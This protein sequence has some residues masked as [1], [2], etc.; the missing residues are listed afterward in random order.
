MARTPLFVLVRY[1][2]VRQN[3]LAGS[4]HPNFVPPRD[5]S[6]ILR[7]VTFEWLTVCGP[8]PG[9]DQSA[10]DTAAASTHRVQVFVVPLLVAG[11]EC[12][13]LCSFVVGHRIA[14]IQLCDR[15]SPPSVIRIP[16]RRHG[17][18]GLER[19]WLA[20]SLLISAGPHVEGRGE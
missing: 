4:S 13:G 18:H 7:T 8:G 1:L 9:P 20:S 14:E 15:V 17:G 19:L 2:A 11:R 5:Q 6:P 3:F 12:P 10:H 16:S